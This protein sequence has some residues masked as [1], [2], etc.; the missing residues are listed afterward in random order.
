MLSE[1]FEAALVY[2]FR[3]HRSQMASLQTLATASESVRRVM[4]AD[5]LHNARSVLMERQQVGDQVWQKFNGGREG[6]LW[7]YR[8]CV[9]IQAMRGQSALGVEL[10]HVV[11]VLET[12][13]GEPQV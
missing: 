13:V 7:F 2:A 8:Q 10:E 12:E 9:E 5:K 11:G 3:L 4:L 1:Q 6:T